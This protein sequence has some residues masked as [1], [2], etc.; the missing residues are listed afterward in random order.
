MG[1]TARHTCYRIQVMSSNV[2]F[3]WQVT[4]ALPSR[5]LILAVE[6]A[7]AKVTVTSP[8]LPVLFSPISCLA[9]RCKAQSFCEARQV[10]ITRGALALA[11]FIGNPGKEK[12]HGAGLLTEGSL[13]VKR[14]RWCIFS[15][16]CILFTAEIMT[17][18]FVCLFL[19]F[20]LG[21]QGRWW[22][23]HFFVIES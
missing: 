12:L 11:G 19:F 8:S 7:P 21:G 2:K 18:W 23:C 22:K 4:K 15:S 5:W 14:G 13:A 10:D 16:G 9:R 6:R 17:P 1:V 20:S 3:S